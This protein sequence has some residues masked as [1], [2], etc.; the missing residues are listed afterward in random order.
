[1]GRMRY[2]SSL[3]SIL[4]NILPGPTGFPLDMIGPLAYSSA[5][6]DMH[7]FY[8]GYGHGYFSFIIKTHQLQLTKE[9]A[10]A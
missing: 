8:D 2:F 6:L 3:H 9:S 4:L 5:V 1:M 10:H 7:Y